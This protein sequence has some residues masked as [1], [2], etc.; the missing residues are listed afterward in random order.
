[1][2][3]L[4][5]K[6]KNRLKQSQT[7]N[8]EGPGVE[9]SSD[10]VGKEIQLLEQLLALSTN[11][12]CLDSASNK[13]LF[14]QSFRSYL[15][16][17][18]SC[19]IMSSLGPSST[20]SSNKDQI[21]SSTTTTPNS[22][23][24]PRQPRTNPNYIN[25]KNTYVR[26]PDKPDQENTNDSVAAEKQP[27]NGEKRSP[28]DSQMAAVLLMALLNNNTA[29]QQSI[30]SQK[31]E[32]PKSSSIQLGTKSVYNKFNQQNRPQN[33]HHHHATS[34][35]KSLI[36]CFMNTSDVESVSTPIKK[37]EQLPGSA[38]TSLTRKTIEKKFSFLSKFEIFN[39][40]FV[41]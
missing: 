15:S 36:S 8:I 6:T 7:T 17:S 14:T 27:Q 3:E 9:S 22:S 29:S 24:T 37:I 16:G 25:V 19:N 1:M 34:G 12:S 10:R 26:V 31:D 2:E 38:T 21:N 32:P 5:E 39:F 18:S 13:D 23:R 11:T 40:S 28:T 20:A 33:N 4:L 35:G 30:G 41:E